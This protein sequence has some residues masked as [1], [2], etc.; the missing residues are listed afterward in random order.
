MK[1]KPLHIFGM[2]MSFAYIFFGLLLL[3]TPFLLEMINNMT[4]RKI[5]GAV[6]LAYGLFRVTYFFRKIRSES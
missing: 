5:L 3:A 1:I 2:V 4:Y 6:S